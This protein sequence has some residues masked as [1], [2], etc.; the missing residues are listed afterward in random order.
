MDPKYGDQDG[1]LFQRPEAGLPQLVCILRNDL[2]VV[3]EAV[4]CVCLDKRYSVLELSARMRQIAS[5]ESS[6]DRTAAEGIGELLIES[7]EQILIRRF[8]EIGEIDFNPCLFE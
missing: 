5:I 8:Q 2:E 4:W 3:V 1:L 6:K 7:R